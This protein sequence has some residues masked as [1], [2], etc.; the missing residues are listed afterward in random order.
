MARFK[1][2]PRSSLKRY[3]V[4]IEKVIQIKSKGKKSLGFGK[5]DLNMMRYICFF[6]DITIFASALTKT[7]V[8]GDYRAFLRLK[9][10]VFD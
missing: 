10:T 3:Q 9:I 8:Y 7:E 4:A 6:L 5:N 1:N 2:D